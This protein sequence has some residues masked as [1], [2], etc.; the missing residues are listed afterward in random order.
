[1]DR[2]AVKS[3]HEADL[4]W[5][6]AS[7]A[8]GK[9]G[10][11]PLGAPL[12]GPQLLHVQIV[13]RIRAT[14]GSG[15]WPPH[16]RLKGEAQLAREFKVSRT[17]VRQALQVLEREGLI[18]RVQGKGTFVAPGAAAPRLTQELLSLGELMERYGVGFQTKLVRCRTGMASAEQ[19]A[20]LGRVPVLSLRRLRSVPEGPVALLDDHIALTR[21]A[22]LETLIRHDELPLFTV[23]ERHFRLRIGWAERTFHA[24]AVPSAVAKAL[25]VEPDSPILSFD[26]VTYLDDDTPIA[27]SKVWLRSDLYKMSTTLRREL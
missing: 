3:G 16:Y 25:A 11:E 14:I 5:G 24:T 4:L 6:V 8:D 2:A 23:L 12:S 9:P 17:V 26:Q 1:M 20:M 18:V 22:G 15:L 21:C 27:H 10:E 13:A 7:T 19:A